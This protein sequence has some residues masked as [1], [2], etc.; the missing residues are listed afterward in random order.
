MLIR[1]RGQILGYVEARD[2]TAAE[3]AAVAEFELSPEQ[4]KRLVVQE[5]G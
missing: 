5:R 4:Q 1:K 2:R 3:L